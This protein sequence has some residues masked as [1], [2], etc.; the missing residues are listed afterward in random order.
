MK[1]KERISRCELASEILWGIKH[2]E[3]MKAHAYS[4][5]EMYDGMQGWMYSKLK[6]KNIHRLDIYKRCIDRL[7]LRLKKALEGVV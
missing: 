1:I 3:A 7:E 2:F 4:S 6:D 5:I